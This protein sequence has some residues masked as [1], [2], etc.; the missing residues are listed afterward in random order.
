MEIYQKDFTEELDF[1]YEI[2]QSDKKNYHA[3]SYR[4]WFIER[5]NL[6]NAEEYEFVDEELQDEPTNNTLWTYRY[7]LNFKTK[8]FNDEFVK[9]EIAYTLK[10]LEKDYTN[11]AAWV[12]L[13]G[14]LA[15]SADEE[16]R[17]KTTNAKRLFILNF[18]EDLK[19]PMLKLLEEKIEHQGNRFIYAVLL[20]FAEAENDLET[21][22]KYLELLKKIDRIRVNYYQWRINKLKQE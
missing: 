22:F 13:R 6:I 18:T 9:A 11:E 4:L 8:P 1:L 2:F 14:Y 17:S 12:Y 15:K 20:D 7:F 3:W 5:F 16:E 19:T 10:K 21:Q